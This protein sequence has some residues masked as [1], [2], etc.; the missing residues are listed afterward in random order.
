MLKSTEYAAIKADCDR[1]SRAHF[2]RSYFHPDGMSFA[3]SETL[4][5]PSE[6]AT[7]LGRE[8]ETQCALLCYGPHPSWAEIQHRLLELRGFL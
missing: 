3:Y 7:I 5:P 8:Y 2:N 1:I 4:F 6:L